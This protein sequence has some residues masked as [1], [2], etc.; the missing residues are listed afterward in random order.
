MG[1][2]TITY[3]PRT[4]AQIVGQQL[5]L[6]QLKDFVLRYTEQKKKAALIYGPIGNGKTCSVYALAQELGYDLIEMNA[7]DIRNEAA[8]RSFLGSTL[9][10]QSL[11]FMPKIILV[12]EIDALSGVHDRGA[13]SALLK[14]LEHSSFPVILTANDAFESKLKSLQKECLMIHFPALDYA[15][16]HTVLQ[17]IC[18]VEKIN[19]EDKALSSLAR[20]ADG[21]L[22]SALIDLQICATQGRIIFQDVA[23]L[24]DRRRKS[25]ILQALA[26]ILKSSSIATA[27]FALDNVDMDMNEIMLWLD[28]NVHREYLSVADLAR[29]YEFLA[30]ADVFQGRIK[31]QQHWRFLSYMTDLLTAGISSA[32]DVRN[33]QFVEY[34]PTMRILQLWQAKMKYGQRKEIAAKMA[35]QGHYSQRRAVGDVSHLR[36]FLRG[37]NSAIIRKELDLTDDEME[38]LRR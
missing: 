11:F 13:V 23:G 27:R 29:A 32:K 28:A 24:S 10:Q 5:G 8:M 37:K 15:V 38:W 16:I 36:F 19:V 7:S 3:A 1:L 30:R 14:A 18:T 25:S 9:G 21:D 12:D 22:R 20:Q 33:A 17:R 4:S 31:R 34:K 6:A 26:I 2:Y 35:R